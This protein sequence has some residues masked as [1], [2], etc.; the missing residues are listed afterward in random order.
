M[1]SKICV[2][3][4]LPVDWEESAAD[5]VRKAQMMNPFNDRAVQ[6]MKN[7]P[8][9]LMLLLG[10]LCGRLQFHQAGDHPTLRRK[11]GRC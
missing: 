2:R 3:T 1:R 7:Q 5:R 11:R 9:I 10:L 4:T 8:T 6:S